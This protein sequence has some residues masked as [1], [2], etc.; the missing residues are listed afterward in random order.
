MLPY[1]YSLLYEAF[2]KG[3]PILRPIFFT[4]LNESTL[5]KDYYETEF[6]IG[7]NI[8]I[9][10][11]MTKSSKREIYLPPGFWY[12]WWRRDLLYE[13]DTFLV[14]EEKYLDI[15]PLFI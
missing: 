15:I 3:Y 12:S 7:D 8:L 11:F 2:S 5:D 14:F 9:T 13:C 6:L 4:D 1:Y 10:P